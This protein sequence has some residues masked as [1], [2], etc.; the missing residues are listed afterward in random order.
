MGTPLTVEAMLDLV[1]SSTTTIFLNN[2]VSEWM[3]TS[4]DGIEVVDPKSLIEGLQ[5]ILDSR[6]SVLFKELV[7]KTISEADAWLD[8]RSPYLKEKYPARLILFNEL[9]S[10]EARRYLS[11]LADGQVAVLVNVNVI[12]EVLDPQ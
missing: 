3:R 10:N 8:S 2:D 7:G 1:K 11:Q 6:P 5:A 12:I 9:W 4:S